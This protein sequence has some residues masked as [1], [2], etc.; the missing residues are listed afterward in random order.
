MPQFGASLTADSR[1]VI[2]ECNMFVIQAST[3][4][5]HP[6]DWGETDWSEEHTSLLK[7]L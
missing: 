1:V 6:L 2:Y 3:G 4:L 7:M 5:L